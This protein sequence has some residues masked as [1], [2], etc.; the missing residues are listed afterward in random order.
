MNFARVPSSWHE[1]LSKPSRIVLS[2]SSMAKQ[3]WPPSRQ[4]EHSARLPG[5]LRFK[6]SCYQYPPVI[7]SEDM[8][9]AFV[10]MME[11]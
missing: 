3:V 6:T 4:R 10:E 1:K 8:A 11:R 5:D 9:A 7:S 2:N